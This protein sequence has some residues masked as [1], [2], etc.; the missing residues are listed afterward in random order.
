MQL[1]IED[2]SKSQVVDL[3]MKK[4]GYVPENQIV[5]RTISIQE[6][7]QKYCYPHGS[8]WVKRNILYPFQ[9][10]WCS[11]IHPGR[12]GKMTIFEQDAAVWMQQHRKEIDWDAK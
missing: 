12:G 8:A 3:V 7:A 9:P 2:H 10:D 1:A 11:N 4:R 6:F 5:G